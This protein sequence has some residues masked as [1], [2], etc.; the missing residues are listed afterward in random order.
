MSTTDEIMGMVQEYASAWSIVGSCFDN[1]HGMECAEEARA[2]LLK[3]V[4]SIAADAR[5]EGVR[6]VQQQTAL[7]VRAAIEL[8][9]IMEGCEAFPPDKMAAFQRVFGIAAAM[10]KGTP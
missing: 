6:S 8:L 4:E 2:A 1:G 3:A 10:Q 5:M 9:E 7:I